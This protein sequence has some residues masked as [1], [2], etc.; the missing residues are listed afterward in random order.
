M[1][2]VFSS[3]PASGNAIVFEARFYSAFTF[4][5]KQTVG[6]RTFTRETNPN[7]VL[8]D[9]AE[10]YFG[11]VLANS[12]YLANPIDGVDPVTGSDR[13]DKDVL[14]AFPQVTTA[15]IFANGTDGTANIRPS[16]YIGTVAQ[17]GDTTGLKK[18]D[19]PGAIDINALAVPGITDASFAAP[20][21]TGEAVRAEL[22]RIADTRLDLVAVPDVPKGVTPQQVVDWG[23][24]AE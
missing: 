1:T 5:V 8:D 21:P 6:A 4:T 13:P 19:A 24:R 7:M 16:D 20:V 3:A 11:T 2:I 17:N 12:V 23:R 14:D 18:Y 15:A 22:L 10:N 9:T